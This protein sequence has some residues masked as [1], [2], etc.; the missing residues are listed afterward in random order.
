MGAAAGALDLWQWRGGLGKTGASDQLL[1][2]YPF[3]RIVHRDHDKTKPLPDFITARANGNPLATGQH[4]GHNLTAIGPGSTT[5]RPAASQ[6]VTAAGEW[7]GNR[8]SVLL[9]RPL[10]V[11]AGG[12]VSLSSGGDYSA[13]FA[14]WDGATRDRG[15]QKLV[16]IWQDLHLE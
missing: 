10:S 5:F 2:E 9:R 11:P 7:N 6:H 8:W 1:D 12:G 15:G 4:A 16:T 13:A 3:D 14:V